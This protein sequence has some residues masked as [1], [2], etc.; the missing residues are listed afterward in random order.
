MTR[1]LARRIVR[2]AVSILGPLM[3]VG[4]RRLALQALKRLRG[5][6]FI[7]YHEVA[8]YRPEALPSGLVTSL[9]RFAQEVA[10][11]R[12][13]FQIISIDE[14]FARLERGCFSS[15][16]IVLCFDDGYR[17]VAERAYPLLAREGIPATLFLNSAFYLGNDV[18]LRLK[19]ELL[20]A[21]YPWEELRRAFPTVRDGAELV[22]LPKRSI[23]PALRQSIETLFQRV[24]GASLSRL[25]LH[26]EDLLVM[27]PEIVTVGNHTRAHAWLPGLNAT[28]QEEE[29]LESHRVLARLRHYR[30]Y[31]AIPFGT[32]DSYDRA[33]LDLVARHYNGYLLTGFGGVNTRPKEDGAILNVRRNAVS[34]QKPPLPELL[35]SNYLTTLMLG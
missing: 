16:A 34:D 6:T 7:V 31:L 5:V 22:A 32:P 14:A 13:H 15:H 25:Y 9:G 35:L 23:P 12:E 21:R 4:H 28:E 18:G 1:P 19:L 30:P 17:G 24:G 3:R 8:D 11:L 27:S 33:T 10:W 2:R 20:L 29:I 26:E